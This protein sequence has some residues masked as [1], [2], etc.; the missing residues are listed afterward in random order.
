MEKEVIS[1]LKKRVRA[2][3]Y[4]IHRQIPN[5]R[6][7]DI[8]KT[9]AFLE[10]K[11]LIYVASSRMNLRTG[12]SVPIY[13]LASKRSSSE[14]DYETI[15]R[16]EIECL[17]A[18]V[19]SA[20]AVEYDFLARNLRS[21][22]RS[23][24]ILDVGSGESLVAEAIK[25][26]GRNKDWE[27]CGIDVEEKLPENSK[28]EE[29]RSNYP[30]MRMDARLMGFRDE[31]FDEIICIGTI[32][33]VGVPLPNRDQKKKDNAGDL[34]AFS[35]IF[36]I[37]KKGGNVVLTLPYAVRRLYREESDYRN[38]SSSRVSD[39][40]RHFRVKKKEFYDYN[41]GKWEKITSSRVSNKSQ[42]MGASEI[43]RF[44]HSRRCV[45]LLLEKE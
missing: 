5:A 13:S 12:L 34:K 33:H 18:G 8:A 36:R 35:E 39:L 44:L 25:K 23:M 17:L 1:V 31:I 19:P 16:L 41:Y 21:H 15:S 26:L 29:G 2:D 11:K 45:C 10:R 32:E 43:P 14:I 24:R 6:M 3:R 28:R 40:I 30:F 38:Y 4:F 22:K 42:P 20:R 7:A 9:I 37:L 27:V